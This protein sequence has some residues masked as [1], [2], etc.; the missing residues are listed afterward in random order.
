[1]RTRT[2]PGGQERP[3]AFR[4]VPEVETVER[5]QGVSGELALRRRGR[6]LEI[7]SNGVFL[8]STENEVSSRALVR[9]A[10][11]LL[12]ARP[13]DVLIG[14]LGVGHALDEALELPGLR[15]LTV[16]EIEPVVVDWFKRYGGLSASRAAIDARVCL[17]IGDVGEVV[18]AA[19]AD[20]D[21]V[22]L[23]TDNGPEW[24]VREANARLYESAGLRCAR[25]VLR[26]GG[27]A[28]FWTMG[29]SAS[30]AAA[31]ER[32]FADVAAVE[33]VDVI[34]GRP[35]TYVIYVGRVPVR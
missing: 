14:G 35:H 15:S 28:A 34:G 8:V 25:A 18:A 4:D 1:L 12:P 3:G 23:D 5:R 7:V 6:H 30:F 33:A 20:Y 9:A 10:R 24:L 2:D 26:P 19:G 13:L 29:A 32:V 21:L 11:P 17:R 31:L 27:A 16:V 22:A